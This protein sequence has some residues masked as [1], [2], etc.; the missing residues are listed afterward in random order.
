VCGEHAGQID[1]APLRGVHSGG[2]VHRANHGLE[3]RQLLRHLQLIRLVEDDHVGRLNLL[4][5]QLDDLAL[6]VRDAV[7]LA[8]LGLL[9]H[10]PL[11]VEEAYERACV[12]HGHKS[13]Q[14]HLCHQ[15]L[16][17]I[18][19]S[20][21]CATDLARL[22]HTGGLHDDVVVPF[23]T[24]RRELDKLVDGLHEFLGHRAARTPV[25][26]LDSVISR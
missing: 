12:H 3:H 25:L 26:Q 19:G 6:R 21:E 22:G 8:E 10:P 24:S 14:L 1:A 15:L 13:M 17:C 9:D 20:L 4:N 18:N 2:G 23:A 5:E 7:V 11:L 16:T